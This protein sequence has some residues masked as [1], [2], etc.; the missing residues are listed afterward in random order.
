M[1]PT[2]EATT[3]GS[4]TDGADARA[5]LLARFGLDAT[6]DDEQ[7]ESTYDRIADYLDEA[8]SDIR[9]WAERRQREA[10]RIFD[11]LTGPEAQL[12]AVVRPPVAAETAPAA[13]PPSTANPTNKLLLGIVAVLVTAAV[14]FGVY[15]VGRPTVPDVTAS[16]GATPTAS[17]PPAVDQAQLAALT[18]KVKADPKDVA[19]LQKIADLYFTANDW[20]NAK[21]AAQKVLAVDPKNEQALVSLGAASYNGGDMAAAEKAWKQGVALFPK[22]AELHYDLGFLYMTTGRGEQMRT[23]WAKVVEIA[24]DSE[25]AK[26]V[27]SQVGEV[28]TPKP[29]PAP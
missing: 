21:A 15:W 3:T 26:T 24:P 17:A 9:G 6:A 19:S 29:S 13:A 18:T 1:A 4:T 2:R 23:E 27:Q 10:D 11:L 7:I 8:P 5:A 14:V 22:N 16:A 12:A 20:T 28:S 25:L